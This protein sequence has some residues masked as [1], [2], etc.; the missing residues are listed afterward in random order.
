MIM[1][2]SQDIAIMELIYN[3]KKIANT[4]GRL[5]NDIF[6][7][8]NFRKSF[9]E[10]LRKASQKKMSQSLHIVKYKNVNWF[11]EYS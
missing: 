7:K 1:D 11:L 5:I 9:L 3:L 2:I 4:I 6:G 8:V 10:S